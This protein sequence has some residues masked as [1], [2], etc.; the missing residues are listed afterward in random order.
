MARNQ[1]DLSEILSE[2]TDLKLPDGRT[3]YIPRIGVK[4]LGEILLIEELLVSGQKGEEVD[5]KAIYAGLGEAN[6]RLV[7]ILRRWNADVL[8][9]PKEVED[10]NGT[11]LVEQEDFSPGVLQTLISLMATGGQDDSSSAAEEIRGVLFAATGEGTD[12]TSNGA[13]KG[14]S[15]PES[16]AEGVARTPLRSASISSKPGSTSGRS[17]AGSRSG[18]SGSRKSRGSRSKRT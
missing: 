2:G 17:A 7:Q 16:G 13:S 9:E 5:A 10:E 8:L 14:G 3:L 6:D 11:K 15:G 1:V 12:E 18:G 4:T